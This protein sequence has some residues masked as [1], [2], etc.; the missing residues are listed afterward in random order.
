MNLLIYHTFFFLKNNNFVDKGVLFHFMNLYYLL[1]GVFFCQKND[2][3]IFVKNS[4]SCKILIRDQILEI[5][6][7]K[8]LLLKSPTSNNGRFVNLMYLMFFILKKSFFGKDTLFHFMYFNHLFRQGVI[9]DR[10]Q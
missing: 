7:S 9:C 1:R 8:C 4:Q 10:K 3:G 5:G 2:K 6:F